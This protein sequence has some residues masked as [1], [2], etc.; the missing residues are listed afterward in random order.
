M[1]WRRTPPDGRILALVMTRY[2]G[3]QPAIGQW[4]PTLWQWAVLVDGGVICFDGWEVEWHPLPT[5]GEGGNATLESLTES[6]P[7][8]N[9]RS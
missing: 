9:R 6:T 5:G 8:S 4:D 2:R 7:G 3:A 1:T